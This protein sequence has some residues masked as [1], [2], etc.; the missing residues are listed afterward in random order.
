MLFI[1]PHNAAKSVIAV[2]YFQRFAAQAGLDLA[3]DSAGADPDPAVWPSVIELLRDDGLQA[4]ERI[5]RHVTHEDL[6][7]AEL[8]ISM[9]CELAA[10]AAHAPG[11][12]HWD[13]LPLAS[14]DLSATRDAIKTRTERL[15]ARLQRQAP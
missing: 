2:A 14:Q 6:A 9:G 10:D 8:V 4:D 15:V 3:A 7:N 13:D 5:P 11:V 1:C 12:E